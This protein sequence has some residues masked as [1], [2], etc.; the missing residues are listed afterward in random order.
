MVDWHCIDHSLL[1]D[2][3][4]NA[5]SNAVRTPLDKLLGTPAGPFISVIG[6][7]FLSP[8]RLELDPALSREGVATS[9]FGVLAK[10]LIE[11]IQPL[12]LQQLGHVMDL[13]ADPLLLFRL[14]DVADVVGWQDCVMVTHIC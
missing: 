7:E 8:I 14:D 2:W 1:K 5:S 12:G 3:K 6:T 13:V 9:V 4:S 11:V 10:V